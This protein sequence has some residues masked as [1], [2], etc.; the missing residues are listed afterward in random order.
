MCWSDTSVPSGSLGESLCLHQAVET[1]HVWVHMP[2]KLSVRHPGVSGVELL[3]LLSKAH[4]PYISPDS[5]AAFESCWKSCEISTVM[6]ATANISAVTLH[7]ASSHKICLGI[8][9]FARESWPFLWVK[10]PALEL[11]SVCSWSWHCSSRFLARALCLKYC[12]QLGHRSNYLCANCCLFLFQGVYF[13]VTCT[14][15]RF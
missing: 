6:S 10:C 1:T 7:L 2:R 9:L 4:V 11:L 13:E 14:Q 3:G 5:L 15:K 12:E 8:F